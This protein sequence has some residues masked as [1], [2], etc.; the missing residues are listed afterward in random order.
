MS[1]SEAAAVLRRA[2]LLRID[3][4]IEELRRLAKEA[5]EHAQTP[6]LDDATKKY[7]WEATSKGPQPP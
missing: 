6:P 7:F 1:P 5:P 2:R 4:R 3:Q